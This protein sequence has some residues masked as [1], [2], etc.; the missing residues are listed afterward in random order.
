M[1][2]ENLDSFD[3]YELN[4]YLF[5]KKRITSLFEQLRKNNYDQYHNSKNMFIIW[6]D[7]KN[8]KQKKTGKFYPDI[9]EQYVLYLIDKYNTWKQKQ[10]HNGAVN[11]YS[12][13]PY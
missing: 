10:D 9:L 1:F 11:K 3:K 4:E 8:G 12:I 6:K 2:E 5:F 13:T 7:L